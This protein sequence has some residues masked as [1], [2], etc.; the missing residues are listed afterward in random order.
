[1]PQTLAASPAVSSRVRWIVCALLFLATTIN[2]MDRSVLSL[3]EP[4]LH[5][6]PFLGWN[7]R[8]P[9]TAQLLFNNNYGNILISFQ[10]AYGLGFLIAGRLIDRLGTKTGYAL[11]ILLWSVSA[12][13]HALV[14]SVLGFAVARF[15]LGLG[16]SGNFPAAIKAITEWFPDE[17]RALAT[18]LFNSGTNAASLVA[19]WAIP[20]ITLR[21]GWQAAFLATGALGFLWLLLWLPFPYN[22]LRPIAATRAS[23]SLT[24][25]IGSQPKN[26]SP[27]EPLSQQ[28]LPAVSTA[29][30]SPTYLAL[31][32]QPTTWAFSAAKLLT[33]P[34]W[35]FYLFWLPKYF[36]ET[37]NLTLTGLGPPI[38][39]IYFCSSFG[40]VAG[41]WLA[42]RRMRQQSSRAQT[43]PVRRG[44]RFALLTC[45]L[46][47]LPVMGVPLLAHRAG[48]ATVWPAV[49][50]LALAA[51]AHQGWSANLYSAPADT[52]PAAQVSTVIGIGSAAGALGGA[53]FTWL[54]KTL[55]NS[56]PLVIFLL[57]ALA[58]ITA[59]T[60][61]VRLS[62]RLRPSALSSPAV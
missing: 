56:H 9:A 46:C 11:A 2:Y 52:L 31:L 33:D 16:E 41:G 22:R 49:A 54:T 42:G 48:P 8:A 27:T 3:I 26:F 35:W 17:Q 62:P 50:L 30:P 20:L 44:R 57:A 51:A 45:A 15:F 61:F 21:F 4:A 6:L 25:S 19:P 7:L 28:T 43:D 58:Y 36:H 18:G 55:W 47:A 23:D 13:A 5:N 60:L 12:M 10:L 40:S 1:M 34:V 32:R 29:L 38:I 14:G 39:V 24:P 53:L 37:Y 59:F